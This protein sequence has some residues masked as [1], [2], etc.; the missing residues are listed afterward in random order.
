MRG[1]EKRGEE[2]RGEG[3]EGLELGLVLWC[4]KRLIFSLPF[5]SSPL[6]SDSNGHPSGQV[7]CVM[8]E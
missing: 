8:N 6:L 1:K 7:G 4:H 2:R 3:E 5:P